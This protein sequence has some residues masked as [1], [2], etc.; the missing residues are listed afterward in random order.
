MWKPLKTLGGNA[1]GTGIRC[2]GLT[3]DEASSTL[4]AVY[5]NGMVRMWDTPTR[6]GKHWAYREVYVGIKAECITHCTISSVRHRAA[7][8]GTKREAP[9]MK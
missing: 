1:V 8:N 7:S 6:G 2:K 9:T 4:G 3:M 5:N